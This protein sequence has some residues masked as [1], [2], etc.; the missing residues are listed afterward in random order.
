MAMCHGSSF[1]HYAGALHDIIQ[2]FNMWLQSP[3]FISYEIH[4]QMNTESV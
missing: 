1:I 3:V 4:V 2:L